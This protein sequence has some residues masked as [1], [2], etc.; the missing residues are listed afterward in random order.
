MVLDSDDFDRLGE[1]FE[2]ERP[3]PVPH[4]RS[5]A[6]RTRPFPPADAVA[7]A[8]GRLREHRPHPAAAD[9]PPG[10]RAGTART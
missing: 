7:F 2:R 6:A 5:G 4:G 1:A 8:E 3:G 9:V 10:G